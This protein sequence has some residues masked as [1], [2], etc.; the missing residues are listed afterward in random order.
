S[1]EG[2]F[3][4][5]LSRLMGRKTRAW[6][7]LDGNFWGGESLLYSGY[8]IPRRSRPVRGS[9]APSLC[10]TP[11]TSPSK[12]GTA[13]AVTA[14]SAALTRTCKWHGSTRGSGSGGDRA[15]FD[16]KHPGLWPMSSRAQNRSRPFC[17]P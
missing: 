14:V 9:V 3:S 13:P 11:H 5:D 10:R 4:R 2:H 12:L 8:R 1:F 17:D 6:V 16:F 15:R 7:S